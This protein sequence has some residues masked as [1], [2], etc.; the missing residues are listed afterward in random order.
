MRAIA[1]T[2]LFA[3]CGCAW[4]VKH[5]PAAAAVTGV[6]LGFITC[7]IDSAPVATCA[8]VGGLVGA[9]L[10]LIALVV[11]L[12]ADTGQHATAPEPIRRPR[13]RVLPPP[14]I[15]AGVA[16]A[17]PL[18]AGADAALTTDAALPPADGG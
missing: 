13:V 8:A 15:D 6:T 1:L 16:D 7:E 2:A 14:P 5:P 12:I 9:G 17:P 11:T 4:L 18:D 10:G 3:L